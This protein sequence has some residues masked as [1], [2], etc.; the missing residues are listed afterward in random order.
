MQVLISSHVLASRPTRRHVVTALGM[1]FALLTA[2]AALVY[3]VF[4][5]NF[6]DRFMPVGRPTTY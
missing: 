4:M 3:L 5:G 1:G 6:L 2:A